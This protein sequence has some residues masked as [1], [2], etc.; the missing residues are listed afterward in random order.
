[1]SRTVVPV[2][3]GQP[4]RGLTVGRSL[5]EKGYVHSWTE[6]QHMRD[7]RHLHV[8]LR[9]VKVLRHHNTLEELDVGLKTYC[10]TNG[11]RVE[12]TGGK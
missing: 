8:T 6:P 9:L 7:G 12:H 10:L 1:M 5:W 2:K 11:D 3:V 4:A